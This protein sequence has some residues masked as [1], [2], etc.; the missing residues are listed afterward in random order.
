MENNTNFCKIQRKHGKKYGN[1]VKLYAFPCD[2][3]KIVLYLPCN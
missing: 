3:N 1:P 2:L